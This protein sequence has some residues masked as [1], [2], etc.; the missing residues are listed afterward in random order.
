M[1]HSDSEIQLKIKNVKVEDKGKYTIMA[2]N[3]GGKATC[4]F[5]VLVEK[6]KK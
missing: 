6:K 2:E 4:D 3:K 1:S 5:Y